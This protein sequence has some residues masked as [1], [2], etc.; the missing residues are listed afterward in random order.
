MTA[1]DLAGVDGCD[2]DVGLWEMQE[3]TLV[4]RDRAGKCLALGGDPVA[5]TDAIEDVLQA[6]RSSIDALAKVAP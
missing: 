6:C 3:L 4:L 2:R 5:I 1:T